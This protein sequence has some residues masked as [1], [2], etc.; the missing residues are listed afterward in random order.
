MPRTRTLAL[1]AATALVAGALSVAPAMPAQA[2]TTVTVTFEYTGGPQT[3]TV[4]DGV[5]EVTVLALGAAGGTSGL[6]SPGLG[7][8]ARAVIAVQPGAEVVVEVGGAGSAGCGYHP[9]YNGG[10]SFTEP[11]SYCHN[12]GGGASDVRVGGAALLDRV[13]VAGGGGGSGSVGCSEAGGPF[14]G[15]AG[16]AGGGLVGGHGGSSACNSLG[17]PYTSGG[18]GTQ[19]N[20]GVNSADAALNG[21]LGQGGPASGGG[22]GGGGGGGHYGGAAGS[23]GAAAG[24]GGSGY[25]PAGTVFESGVRSGDGSVSITYVVPDPVLSVSRLGGGAGTV[26]SDVGGIDCGTDCEESFPHRTTVSLTATPEPGSVFAGWGGQCTGTGACEV[27]MYQDAVVTA[28]FEQAPEPVTLSV[29]TTGEGVGSVT[30]DPAGIDCGTDCAEEYEPGTVVS[31]TATPAAGSSF[32]GWAGACTGVGACSVT[33][34]QVRSV[35][36]GFAQVALD[37]SDVGVSPRAFHR[38]GNQ[39]R[40]ELEWTLSEAADLRIKVRQLC[41]GDPCGK[42]I[43]VDHSAQAGPGSMGFR[44]ELAPRKLRPGRH[45]VVVVAVTDTDRDREVTDFRVRRG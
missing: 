6:G 41:H 43:R 21:A 33:M 20:G 4:P 2:A 22:S 16:G 5:T 12:S 9:G 32:T 28:T 34:D 24:G 3:W 26:S 13:L 15:N 14:L 11:P 36:A 31:L 42:R 29:S 25:G 37:V 38:G 30:S 1:T 39:T 10:G 35:T 17:V 44:G 40:P 27:L 18:G 19:D 23:N 7:G 8:S 45:R